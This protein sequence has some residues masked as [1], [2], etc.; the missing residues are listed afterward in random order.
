MGQCASNLGLGLGVSFDR[1]V[2]GWLNRIKTRMISM[3]VRDDDARRIPQ[4]KDLPKLD[5]IHHTIG[6]DIHVVNT[7][8]EPVLRALFS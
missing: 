6:H 8:A 3:C 4:S 1:A 5:K 2:F 7:F